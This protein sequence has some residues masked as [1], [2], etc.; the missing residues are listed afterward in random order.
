[1]ARQCKCCRAV[2]N[3]LGTASSPASLPATPPHLPPRAICQAATNSRNPHTACG[4]FPQLQPNGTHE[5]LGL[6]T[7]RAVN[8]GRSS[9]VIWCGVQNLIRP[10][11]CELQLPG[12]RDYCL[13]V[14]PTRYAGQDDRPQ[15]VASTLPEMPGPS[16]KCMLSL[17]MP[18]AV[19]HFYCTDLSLCGWLSTAGPAVTFSCHYHSRMVPCA[20]HSVDAVCID[21]LYQ[22]IMRRPQ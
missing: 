8:S 11:V 15:G 17:D 5:Q 20:W 13:A 18:Q 6:Q 4:R 2:L 1:M 19:G 22:T 9:R 12:W 3:L 7:D 16:G 10:S 21:T 14:R